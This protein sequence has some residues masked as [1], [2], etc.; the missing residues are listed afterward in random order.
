MIS[1]YLSMKV[2][3]ATAISFGIRL[4]PELVLDNPN[5]QSRGGVAITGPIDKG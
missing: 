5:N 1:I 3:V 2:I 4:D